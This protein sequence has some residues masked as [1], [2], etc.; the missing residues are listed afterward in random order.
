M[1][2]FLRMV[3]TQYG[4]PDQA[5]SFLRYLWI[6]SLILVPIIVLI[7]YW[8]LFPSLTKV[9]ITEAVKPPAELMAEDEEEAVAEKPQAKVEAEAVDK[10]R[11]ETALRVLSDDE[12]KVVQV[13]MEAG[14]QMLQKEISWETGF[15]RVKTHR[16]L[17]RLLRRGLVSAEKYYNTNRITLVDWLLKGRTAKREDSDQTSH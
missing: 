5:G 7:I 1:F 2:P 10:A 14:G 15:S 9:K 12:G 13:L 4:P 3:V 6:L 17:V 11:V 8:L 16:V